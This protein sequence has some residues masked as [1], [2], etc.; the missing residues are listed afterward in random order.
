MSKPLQAFIFDL[1]GVITDTAEYHYLAWKALGEEIGVPFTREFNEELKGVSRMDSLEK[2]LS[3]GNKQNDF[4]QAK[5]EALAASK[6][7]HY[8]RLIEGISPNDILIGIEKLIADI[9]SRGYKLG[10]ASVSKNAFSVMDKLGLTSQ[11]DIIVD[12]AKI[13]NG[14]PDPEIFLKAAE[15]LN[16]EPTAC[17]GIED[18]AAGV[19]SIK[20]AGMFAVGVGS[21]DS[22]NKADIVYGSTKELSLDRILDAYEK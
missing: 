19:D 21:V 9:K 5:K 6:N 12:A 8:V 2:I 20:G 17:I 3:L 10:L 14:K 4:T 11:F 15:M 16:V 13:K 7:D 18:A 1:D 22:L